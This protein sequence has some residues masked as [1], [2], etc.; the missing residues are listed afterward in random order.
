MNQIGCHKSVGGVVQNVQCWGPLPFIK[1]NECKRKFPIQVCVCV[2]VVT[3]A[4]RETEPHAADIRVLSA[5]SHYR[6]CDA[7]S[8]SYRD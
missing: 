4:H 2:C 8:H 1:S 7:Q 6:S 5:S 3:T